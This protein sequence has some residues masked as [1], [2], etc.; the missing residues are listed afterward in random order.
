MSLFQNRVA[1]GRALAGALDHYAGRRD[2]VVL[3]LPRGGV[4]VAFEVAQALHLPLDIF[5]VRK[6]GLPGN[7]ELA[8]GALAAGAPP[9][10]NEDLMQILGVTPAA[11]AGVT[12]RERAEVARR[13][14]AYR[15]DQPPSALKDRVLIV[16]DDGLATG[17]TMRAAVRALRQHAPAHIVIA[18]PVC[19]REAREELS[20]ESDEM[21]CLEAPE[22]FFAISVWYDEFPQTSDEEVRTLLARARTQINEKSTRKNGKDG[23]KTAHH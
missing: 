11:I 15:G 6:I 9:V 20:T 1:A 18:V 17:A 14:R 19:S 2:A 8:L 23:G 7:E 16:V 21:I 3:A 5:V 13:E 4:P 22:S 12:E 10:L